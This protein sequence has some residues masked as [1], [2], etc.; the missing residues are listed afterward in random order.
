MR[1]ASSERERMSAFTCGKRSSAGRCSLLPSRKRKRGDLAI[2]RRAAVVDPVGDEGGLLLGDHRPAPRQ[3]RELCAVERRLTAQPADQARGGAA[4]RI[5]RLSLARLG[6]LPVTARGL[7]LAFGRDHPHPMD[8][9]LEELRHGNRQNLP[10][11]PWSAALL[12]AARS[13]IS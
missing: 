11:P 1:I 13:R 2:V 10:W 6:A 8:L 9:S 7:D 12:P 4:A 3:A 5:A